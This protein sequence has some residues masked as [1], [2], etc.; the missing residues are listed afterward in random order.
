M[1][2]KL[3]LNACLNVGVGK[4]EGCLTDRHFG[5]VCWERLRL[6]SGGPIIQRGAGEGIEAVLAANRALNILRWAALV[7][8]CIGESVGGRGGGGGAN[9]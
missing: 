1:F 2:T 3:L 8:V 5:S 9:V 6:E 7:G 4:E